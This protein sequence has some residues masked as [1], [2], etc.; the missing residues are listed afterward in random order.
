MRTVKK[1]DSP[2]IEPS[3]PT[4]F[5]TPQAK[6]K[7]W[8][9]LM[10]WVR[11][12]SSPA[13]YPVEQENPQKGSAVKRSN[14]FI[15]IFKIEH[16]PLSRKMLKSAL[17]YIRKK[18]GSQK[19]EPTSFAF[20]HLGDGRNGMAQIVARQDG[21]T[22]VVRKTGKYEEPGAVCSVDDEKEI[23]ARLDHPNIVKLA[24]GWEE[25]NV[26][27][28]MHVELKGCTIKSLFPEAQIHKP[29]PPELSLSIIRQ[30][31]DALA[32]L[33]KE[34]I[35]HR[36]LKLE[37]IVIAPDGMVTLIDFGCA[38]DR[39]KMG[40]NC[41]SIHGTLTFLPP[42]VIRNKESGIFT[43]DKG[44]S[45]MLGATLAYLLTGQ[46]PDNELPFNKQ[47]YPKEMTGKEM[48]A[49]F[50]TT[51]KAL[52]SVNNMKKSLANM[53]DQFQG[54]Y[55]NNMEQ[56]LAGLLHPDINK[57]LT[58]EDALATFNRLFPDTDGSV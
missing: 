24:K 8:Q 31:L 2:Q 7:L 6:P 57:R 10:R 33:Q 25:E 21:G 16:F 5:H 1:P 38:I 51:D 23:I 9:R 3:E 52:H 56:L 30:L 36:D 43:S 48:W 54:D 18:M 13:I 35:F 22:L 29:L 27:G 49:E 41:R 47:D 14:Q 42:E 28:T 40:S 55:V 50:V 19:P 26:I 46:I 17:T 53:P 37:N 32:Y 12:A 4:A 44:D 20:S 58:A 11:L 45:Y 15:K 39:A 34:Q